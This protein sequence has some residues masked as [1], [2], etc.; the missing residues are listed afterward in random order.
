MGRCG[1]RVYQ[2]LPNHSPHRNAPG[3][4]RFTAPCVP[5]FRR[6][7][8][9]PGRRVSEVKV[10]RGS[11]NGNWCPGAGWTFRTGDVRGVKMYGE[12]YGGSRPLRHGIADLLLLNYS[13]CTLYYTFG[14]HLSHLT[15]H[16]P[17]P[18]KLPLSLNHLPA[19]WLTRER[20]DKYGQVSGKQR[21]TAARVS[22]IS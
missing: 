17:S 2:S 7:P 4:M 12:V 16:A 13:N 8:E 9:G 10:A 14:S 5:L 22:F 20:G 1:D 11:S 19:V 3:L 6:L 21:S 15:M 18:T